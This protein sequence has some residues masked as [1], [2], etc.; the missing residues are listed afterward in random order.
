MIVN[1]VNTFRPYRSNTTTT[2][3]VKSN[4]TP[5]FMAKEKSS[6]PRQSM[7]RGLNTWLMSLILGT[8]LNC[9]SGSNMPDAQALTPAL[10][11]S[12]PIATIDSAVPTAAIDTGANCGSFTNNKAASLLLD[13]LK[14]SGLVSKYT[15]NLPCE[16]KYD[17]PLDAPTHLSETLNPISTD[18]EIVYSGSLQ[19]ESCTNFKPLPSTMTFAFNSDGTL[20]RTWLINGETISVKMIPGNHLFDFTGKGDLTAGFKRIAPETAGMFR[21]DNLE[22][23]IYTTKWINDNIPI[24]T[25]LPK[26]MESLAE[27][28]GKVTHDLRTGEFR[29]PLGEGKVAVIADLAK[30]TLKRV[31]I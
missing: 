17:I 11:A 22:V 19:C 20:T 23:P 12:A 7:F 8:Q 2:N 27:R 9:S 31:R 13:E 1:S 24:A 15:E 30:D 28:F 25:K 14:D 4:T 18:T 10:D 29:V 26:K 5:A 16:M 3:A 6:I 21:S